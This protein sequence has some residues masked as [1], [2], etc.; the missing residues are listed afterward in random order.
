M[1]TTLMQDMGM[2]IALQNEILAMRDKVKT[3]IEQTQHH[4]ASKIDLLL[5]TWVQKKKNFLE[6]FDWQMTY[7]LPEVVE[8]ALSKDALDKLLVD[9]L[10]CFWE[11]DNDEISAAKDY[12][13]FEKD[14][15]FENKVVKEYRYKDIIVPEGSKLLKGLKYFITD[16]DKLSYWQDE[17]SRIIQQA[18]VSGV[19]CISVNPLDFLT[20]SENAH[21]WRSC[22]ALDG[23]FRAGNLSYIVDSATVICYLRA[24]NP[25][26]TIPYLPIKWNSKKWR[27]LLFF[28]DNWDKV[29]AGRQ[30]PFSS[31]Y[32]IEEVKDVLIP[33]SGLGAFCDWNDHYIKEVPT[34]NGSVNHVEPYFALQN[35][36]VALNSI[37]HD[38]GTLHYNDLLCSSIYKNPLFAFR[39]GVTSVFGRPMIASA[40]HKVEIG[41]PVYCLHCGNYQIDDPAI[42]LCEDCACYF[43]F[44]DRDDMSL[45]DKCGEWIDNY[46]MIEVASTGEWLCPHC[47]DEYTGVCEC[48]DYTFY[49]YELHEHKKTQSLVCDICMEALKRDEKAVA[50]QQIT[51]YDVT[52]EDENSPLQL[53]STLELIQQAADALNEG[54]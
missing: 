27:T 18:K 39:L 42:M 19:L 24:T 26:M 54:M 15:F 51:F 25:E 9:F 40:K 2:P 32:L 17:A 16:K 8:A 31:D 37:I 29:F 3:V 38:N 6:A 5:D 28:S 44:R 23:D 47:A 1:D 53:E 10:A 48:C 11:Y 41:G 13:L 43:G 14:G 52:W 45:C 46:D 34:R 22:H 36:L 4:D 33:S 7:E 30:Y 21:N 35:K 20:S 49:N 12:L 50:G